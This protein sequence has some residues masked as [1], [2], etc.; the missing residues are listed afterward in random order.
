MQP[1]IYSF[2][3]HQINP[4]KIDN[5]VFYIINKLRQNGFSAYLV[6]GSVRDLLLDRRP[7]DFDI[8]TSA[9]PEEIK[10][11]FRSCLLIGKRFRLAHVR[12]G[13]KIIEVSTFRAGDS[14]SGDLIV[15]DN[16]WGSP[17]EDVMRRDFTIN[18]L[19][20]DPEDETIID[21]VGGVKDAKE[22]ILKTIG[23]PE[24][25]FRQDPVR[26]IRLLKFKARFDLSVDQLALDALFKSKEEILKSSQAR[27]LEELFKMLESGASEPFFKYLHEYGLLNLL[28]PTFSKFLNKSSGSHVYEFLSEVD[29]ILW[30][31]LNAR[32]DRSILLSCILFPQLEEVIQKYIHEM[33]KTP[34]LGI[35]AN[36]SNQLINDVFRPFFL[37]PKKIKIKI[38]SILTAQYRFTPINQKSSRRK[39]V[40]K[41]PYFLNSFKFFKIRAAIDPKLLKS[42]TE[43]NKLI[44]EKKSETPN[45]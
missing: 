5:H 12:F 40:S 13:K 24:I 37:I 45:A 33:Q 2:E 30:K 7:K 32:I 35:I 34:H 9:K 38:I 15:R 26:M 11:V 19:F 41:D 21:Y 39:R 3:Q 44:L 14:E 18:G 6:G 27:I 22:K 28:T 42:Y 31:D 25:R 4:K 36:I 43:W 20:Y 23:I 16:V 17:E 10:K 1:Q 29:E 8:S